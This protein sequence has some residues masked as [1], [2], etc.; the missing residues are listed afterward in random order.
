MFVRLHPH[1]RIGTVGQRI[2]A[3]GDLTV[4]RFR[5]GMIRAST[6]AVGNECRRDSR[7]PSRNSRTP[8]R[9]CRQAGAGLAQADV[10]HEQSQRETVDRRHSEVLTAGD[11]SR[12]AR[13]YSK[14]ERERGEPA[15]GRGRLRQAFRGL[16]DTAKDLADPKGLLG[17]GSDMPAGIANPVEHAASQRRAPSP[18]RCA[19]EISGVALPRP[20]P[21]SRR[22]AA[23]STTTSPS[24]WRPA[25]S[26]LDPTWCT[27]YFAY[28]IASAR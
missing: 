3:G 23:H 2:L 8:G 9:R 18:R 4:S 25:E 5:R 15:V 10:A 11:Y 24:S 17:L 20:S 12:Q 1:L 14:A 7:P 22:V 28:R 26:P 19:G 27:A 6:S 21:G 13:R 16:A